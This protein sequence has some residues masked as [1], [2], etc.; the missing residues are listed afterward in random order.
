MSPPKFKMAYQQ[1]AED[2]NL[3]LSLRILDTNAHDPHQ[4]NPPILDE[5][6]GMIVDDEN[7]ERKA[8]REIVIEHQ[9]CGF[10]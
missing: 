8:S 3:R 10:Q 2:P 5:I 1:I 6:A 9:Q 7:Y 4:Y